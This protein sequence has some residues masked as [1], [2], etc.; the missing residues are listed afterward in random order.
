MIRYLTLILAIASSSLALGRVAPAQC[1]DWAP[2]F[3]L[4]GQGMNNLVADLEVF[5]DGNGPK[6]YAT[7]EFTQAGGQP[8]AYIACWNGI[9]WS[10]VGT[11]LDSAGYALEVHSDGGAASLYVGGLFTS[12]GGQLAEHVAR[13]DGT[14]WHAVGGGFDNGLVHV[15]RSFDDGSGPKLYAGGQFSMVEGSPANNIAVWD[16]AAWSTLGDG[17]NSTVMAIEVYDEGAGDVLFAAGSFTHSGPLLL[18][19]VARWNGGVWTEPNQGILGPVFD[20]EV[21]DD[22]SGSGPRLW[23]GG[24]FDTAGGVNDK[25]NIAGWNGTTWIA[26]AQG[27]SAVVGA[28]E[29]FDDGILPFLAVGGFYSHVGGLLVN[30]IAGWN[31]TS[32]FALGPGLEPQTTDLICQDLESFDDGSGARLF[33]A[34]RFVKAGGKESFH[35]G[36]WNDACSAPT[37]TQQPQDQTAVFASTII[38]KVKA[39]GTATVQYQWRHDGV[40]IVDQ[41]GIVEGAQTDTLTHWVWSYSDHGLYDVVITNPFGTV[42]SQQ[43]MLTVPAGGLSGVPVE[44]TVVLNPPEPTA[45]IPGSQFTNFIEALAS[46]TDEVVFRGELNGFQR[47]LARW[48]DGP[49]EVLFKTG[50]LAPGLAAGYTL[51]AAN[52]GGESIDAFVTASDGAA[53]FNSLIAGPGVTIFNDFGI[54]HHD[55]TTTRLVVR[56]GDQATGMAAGIV[57]RNLS[58]PRMSETG[59]VVYSSETYLNGVFQKSGLWLWETSGTTTLLA[60]TTSIAPG[61]SALLTSFHSSQPLL[62]PGGDVVFLGRLDST[63]GWNYGGFTDSA[64]WRGGPSGLQLLAKSGDPAPG[65]PAGCNLEA[66]RSNELLVDGTGRVVFATWVA[67]PAGFRRGA[68]YEW[69]QGTLIP[70]ALYGQQAPGTEPGSLFFV[71]TPVAIAAPDR[72]LFHSGLENNCLAGCPTEGLWLS[73]GGTILPVALKGGDPL[74]GLP[75]GFLVGEFT[76]GAVNDSGQVAFACTTGPSAT[77]YT[78]VFGWSEGQGVFPIAV[79]GSQIELGPG[80]YKMVRGADLWPI[81]NGFSDSPNLSPSGIATLVLTFTDWSRVVAQGSMTLFESLHFGSGIAYCFGDGSGNACPC[82]NFGAPGSGCANSSGEGTVLTAT[83]SIKVSDDE[84]TFTASGLPSNKISLLFEGT[85]TAGGGSG[86][87]LGD[88]L[89]CV[90]GSTTRITFKSSGPLG[91]AQFGPGLAG[92][93]HWLGG[94]TWN[95][96]VWYRDPLGPCGIGNNLSNGYRVTFIP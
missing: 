94:Q 91:F 37:I 62:T 15:L 12:A 29:V 13:W 85:A 6:L 25:K 86:V 72:V 69:D 84:L 28:L 33:A 55:G 49:S 27:P 75:E 63:T 26:T 81:A 95:F 7:G 74:P 36:R 35:V 52:G 88:G 59:R 79:P 71:P 21:F 34:G 23:A 87:L 66:F 9:Q 58:R 53:C 65:M 10:P 61:T 20:L 68:L 57:H 30:N 51:G 16:G 1:K 24:Q 90:G 93:A 70:I 14:T 89:R 43:A 8:V 5:D 44:L 73:S 76:S 4:P 82:G 41:V 39:H 2:V 40:P 96:Q 32:W 38:Q 83:G 77:G 47:C 54:W 67:G 19:H 42:V 18:R 3:A 92:P 11:G 48:T 64:L 80:D 17:F 56:E 31:G 50:D 46:P 60:E 45:N 22:G 78:G